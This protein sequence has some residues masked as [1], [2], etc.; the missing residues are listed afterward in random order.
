MPTP[1]SL[2]QALLTT[3]DQNLEVT[4]AE[5]RTPL[6]VDTGRSLVLNLVKLGHIATKGMKDSFK[7]INSSNSTKK[8]LKIW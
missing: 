7:K 3:L 2:D 8:F 5:N 4:K 6:P 1:W